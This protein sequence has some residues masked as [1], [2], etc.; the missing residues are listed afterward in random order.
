MQANIKGDLLEI[1]TKIALFTTKCERVSNSSFDLKF[2]CLDGIAKTKNLPCCFSTFG[3]DC[4]Y[5]KKCLENEHL[6]TKQIFF[7]VH[8]YWCFK[9][10]NKSYSNMGT[11]KFLANRKDKAEKERI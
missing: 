3:G 4:M 6:N 2:K 11:C 9:Y 1:Q 5:L 7:L 10:A 8:V